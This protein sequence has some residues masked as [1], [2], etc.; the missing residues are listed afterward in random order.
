MT[1]AGRTKV[2][3]ASPTLV[4]ASELFLG[5]WRIIQMEKWASDYLDVVE[6]AHITFGPVEDGDHA[7]SAKFAFSTVKGWLDCRSIKMMH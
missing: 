7:E 3:T 4:G 1:P 6:P 2:V 5:K